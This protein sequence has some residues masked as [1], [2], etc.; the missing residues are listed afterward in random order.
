[1][2]DNVP[3]IPPFTAHPGLNVKNR[4]NHNFVFH[5]K[6]PLVASIL[7][8]NTFMTNIHIVEASRDEILHRI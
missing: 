7:S 1:M 5:H 6:A 4:K 3:N 8:K 2:E